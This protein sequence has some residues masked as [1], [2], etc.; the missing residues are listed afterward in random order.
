M[1]ADATARDSG[2]RPALLVDGALRQP[3]RDREALPQAGQ[4]VGRPQSQELLPRVHRVAVLQGEG[5]RGRD[6]LDVGQQEAGESQARQLSQFLDPD[7]AEA[8]AG[9]LEL[10]Q[11]RGQVAHDLHALLL[12]VANRSH[13]ER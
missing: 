13:H 1:T 4:E 5:P 9:D 12:D 8:P 7:G 3:A 10:R 2:V 11:P 6:A